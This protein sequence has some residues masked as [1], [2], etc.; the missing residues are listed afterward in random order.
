ML[1]HASTLNYTVLTVSIF[2]FT[3]NQPQE[4]WYFKG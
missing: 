3:Y 1:S 2:Y 4:F